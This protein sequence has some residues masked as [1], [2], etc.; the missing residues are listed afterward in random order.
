[1]SWLLNHA[2]SVAI[3]SY[4]SLILL[5][6]SQFG[7]HF[8]PDFAILSGLRSDYLSPIFYFS[9]FFL[10]PLT[11]FLAPLLLRKCKNE[12]KYFFVLS[13]IG[14]LT[15]TSLFSPQP[16]NSIYGLLRWCGYGVFAFAT[17]YFW[18]NTTIRTYSLY[19]LTLAVLFASGLAV[20]QFI[21][22]H[23]VGGIFYFFGERTFS[24]QTPGIANASLNGTLILRPYATFPHPN[25]LA[26]FLLISLVVLWSYRKI[27]YESW[28]K[29]LFISATLLSISAMLFALS[30]TVIFLMII[31]GGIFVVS[32]LYKKALAKKYAGVMGIT[33]VLILLPLLPRFLAISLSDETVTIRLALLKQSWEIFQQFPLFGVGLKNFLP[34]LAT[35]TTTYLPY[36]FLQPVH[37][38]FV[39]IIVEVGLVGMIWVI[40]FFFSLV[41]RV[42]VTKG[43]KPFLFICVVVIGSVDHYFYTLHQGQ[44]LLALTLG[45]LFSPTVPLDAEGNFA[46]QKKQISRKGLPKE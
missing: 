1:M 40:P 8:W 27:F 37:N 25:V 17:W 15:I 30:R 32:Q 41:K 26:G 39:L 44:L 21:L 20:I 45:I 10:I 38:I 33:M 43:V 35:I 12:K 14:Y 22:Q 16:L 13:F 28:E 24:G 2:N 11:L 9:D 7:Y 29:L 36:S 23:S 31:L 5:L 42:S 3:F 46:S 6:P 34:V 19:T 4:L 18:Q